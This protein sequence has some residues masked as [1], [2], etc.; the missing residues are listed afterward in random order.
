MII[1]IMVKIGMIS[2]PKQPNLNIV[3]TVESPGLDVRQMF[4]WDLGH[5]AYYF[6]VKQGHPGMLIEYVKAPVA[7]KIQRFGTLQ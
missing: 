6:K 3:V 4:T 1:I 5:I 7:I 2:M